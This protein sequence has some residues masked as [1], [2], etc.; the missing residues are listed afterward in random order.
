MSHYDGGNLHLVNNSSN[1]LGA[2]FRHNNQGDQRRPRDNR[3][4]GAQADD[5][6]QQAVDY[7]K[8]KVEL[9]EDVDGRRRIVSMSSNSTQSQELHS[10]TRFAAFFH[11]D[12]VARANHELISNLKA[13]K[14]LRLNGADSIHLHKILGRIEGNE[15]S[16]GDLVKLGQLVERVYNQRDPVQHAMRRVRNLKIAAVCSADREGYVTWSD[17]NVDVAF[18]SKFC[19]WSNDRKKAGAYISAE[20]EPLKQLVNARGD[21]SDRQ[22]FE[23]SLE[24]LKA[25]KMQSKDMIELTDLVTRLFDPQGFARR[26]VRRMSRMAHLAEPNDKTTYR[27]SLKDYKLTT[28]CLRAG[29]ADAGRR[30]AKDLRG[31]H[32]VFDQATDDDKRRYKEIRKIIVDGNAKPADFCLLRELVEKQDNSLG[33]ALKHLHSMYSKSLTAKPRQGFVWSDHQMEVV[34]AKPRDV[35]RERQRYGRA[36]EAAR[37]TSPNVR[38]ELGT[39]PKRSSWRLDG[40]ID[41]YFNDAANTAPLDTMAQAIF[42]RIQNGTATTTDYLHLTPLVETQMKLTNGGTQREQAMTDALRCLWDLETNPR[43]GE[44]VRVQL[45]ALQ[46]LFRDKN[47]NVSNDFIRLLDSVAH[48][49]EIV[50]VQNT[51]IERLSNLVNEVL[52]QPAQQRRRR[53]NSDPN[54]LSAS[55]LH[56]PNQVNII[57]GNKKANNPNM[58]GI[59]AQPQVHMPN[60]TH[61]GSSSNQS[62][63]SSSEDDSDLPSSQAQG[64][65][66]NENPPAHAGDDAAQPPSQVTAIGPA[67]SNQR[68]RMLSKEY[69]Q[70]MGNMRAIDEAQM[71]DIVNDMATGGGDA[72]DD[73][74][75]RG[76]RA[77]RISI[78]PGGP[79]HQAGELSHISIANDSGPIQ[80]QDSL[81]IDNDRNLR[82]SKLNMQNTRQ[83]MFSENSNAMGLTIGMG[84]DSE[85]DN[86][87]NRN[88]TNSNT[89]S[90]DDSQ[91][92]TIGGSINQQG[93]AQRQS[94]QSRQR[95]VSRD[96]DDTSSLPYPGQSDSGGS[97][98][99]HELDA[100]A[101]GAFESAPF[102]EVGDKDNRDANNNS[103]SNVNAGANPK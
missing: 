31:L 61:V 32:E 71:D 83:S 87:L 53:G 39:A 6:L 73:L 5:D 86:D 62:S 65:M 42:R 52:K 26:T 12:R 13:L 95:T 10:L 81:D 14:H 80:P 102:S 59:P 30:L 57:V 49:D 63:E 33:L 20:L 93:N 37:N 34:P 40:L 23:R 72:E 67:N 47:G 98:V 27:D 101:D 74:P 103:N 35:Q 17:K 92:I 97:N 11:P 3:N 46:E 45:V 51:A 43:S 41:R 79:Q 22:L 48:P 82:G 9:F 84:S 69:N 56:A 19:T 1:L 24:Q 54:N 58:A 2:Q 78:V 29:R 99:A 94:E 18:G 76:S 38:L 88:R 25:G 55:M 21:R 85:K 90:L 36:A 28:T 4:R 8:D 96:S 15:A 100:L 75:D 50:G 91:H 66:N 44:H 70:H 89:P 60:H 68:Q 64:Q 7:L 16:A 77:N